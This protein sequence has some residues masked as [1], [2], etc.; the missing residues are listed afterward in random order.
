VLRVGLVVALSLAWV[1]PLAAQPAP[2]A[3]SGG[4]SPYEE[5]A[6]QVAERELGTVRE[7]NAEGQLVDEVVLRRLEPIEPRDPIPVAVNLLH[8]ESR[9]ATLRREVVL[10]VG[11]AFS[12]ARCD[13]S[14]RRLRALP[15][16]SLVMCVPLRAGQPGRVKVLILTKDVWSL[17]LDPDFSFEG[18]T[19]KLEPKESNLLGLHHVVFARYTRDPFSQSW[20]GDYTIPRFD[21]QFVT[22]R[23]DA[24]VVTNA[25]TGRAEGSFG[26]FQAQGVARSNRDPWNWFTDLNWVERPWR[27]ADGSQVQRT[28]GGVTLDWRRSELN[29]TAAVTR[30]FGWRYKSDLTVGLAASKTGDRTVHETDLELDGLLTAPHRRVG[31]TIEGHFY[32]NDFLRTYEL[33]TLGLQEDFRLGHDLLVNLSPALQFAPAGEQVRGPEQRSFLLGTGAT[34]QETLALG[35]GFVRAAVQGA[36]DFGSDGSQAP[37]VKSWLRV[38]TP[39]LGFGRFVADSEVTLNLDDSRTRETVSYS[40]ANRLRGY[41]PNQ[42]TGRRVGVANLEYRSPAL[43]LWTEQVGAVVFYDVGAQP[44]SDEKLRVLSSVGL[45]LRVV[46]PLLERA[47]LRLDFA[48]PLSREPGLRHSLFQVAFGQAFGLPDVSPLKPKRFP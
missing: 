20:G 5:Q 34:L 18:S 23:A 39:R 16:L 4:Y 22:L 44:D 42:L 28:K 38:A 30:S 33:D 8:V 27:V 21:G 47:G 25:E 13:E 9:E 19:L 26:G 29:G 10:R 48:L 45:G 24:N 14:A 46:T 35:N 12:R 15:Q 41:A 3:L 1:T 31:P 43:Q 2:R 7:P 37:F 32:T 40:N 36:V 6:L 17:F 11:A